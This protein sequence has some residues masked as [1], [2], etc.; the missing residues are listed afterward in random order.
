M[1]EGL[2]RL[3]PRKSMK[4]RL[5]AV[6]SEKQSRELKKKDNGAADTDEESRK[7][8]ENGDGDGKIEEKKS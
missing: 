2:S 1:F 8:D 5:G 6:E 3:A 4:P 7:K